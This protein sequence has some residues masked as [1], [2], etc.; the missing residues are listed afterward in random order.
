MQ[1]RSHY[2]KPSCVGY[3][4]GSLLAKDKLLMIHR[5]LIELI[6]YRIDL[7]IS[8]YESVVECFQ[9]TPFYF[10]DLLEGKWGSAILEERTIYILNKFYRMFNQHL[11]K[12]ILHKFTIVAFY[13][14]SYAPVRSKLIE[15]IRE[16]EADFIL[17]GIQGFISYR[18][19]EYILSPNSEEVLK[20]LKHLK[21]TELIQTELNNPL[22]NAINLQL[23]EMEEGL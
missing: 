16:L 12:S 22:L 13:S 14:S 1:S 6:A 19:F 8:L 4:G 10:K 21:N 18:D 20:Y 2:F 7:R 9:N 15:G 11:D 23:S 3:E 17:N 5:D